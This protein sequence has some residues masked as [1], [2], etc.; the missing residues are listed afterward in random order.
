MLSDI[1]REG[2][3]AALREFDKVGRAAFLERYGFGR[4]MR[5]EHQTRGRAAF[6]LHAP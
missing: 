2:V 4:S 6:R 3:E 5:R 1:T